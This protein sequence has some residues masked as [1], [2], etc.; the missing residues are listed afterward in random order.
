MVSPSSALDT[1]WRSEPAPLSL[2][3]ETVRPAACAG[4]GGATLTPSISRQK[5]RKIRR[6]EQGFTER[7]LSVTENLINV[8][9]IVRKDRQKNVKKASVF[10]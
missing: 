8:Y 7:I 2:Q 9:T 3:L 4:V 5:A 10:Q 1:A 6:V